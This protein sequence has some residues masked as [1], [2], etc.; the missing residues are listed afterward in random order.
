MVELVGVNCDEG[1]EKVV[2]SDLEILERRSGQEY[3]QG[4]GMV[5]VTKLLEISKIILQK[6]SKE[7]PN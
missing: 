1:V 3:E 2:Q 4:Y 5:D 6:V 7:I